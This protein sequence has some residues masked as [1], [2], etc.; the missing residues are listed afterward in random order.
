MLATP[1]VGHLPLQR[2]S[3]TMRGVTRQRLAPQSGPG[4]V[5]RRIWR[6]ASSIVRRHIAYL[7]GNRLESIHSGRPSRLIAPD[8]RDANTPK[9]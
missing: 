7:T 2:E 3:T 6:A 1:E 9:K 8:G 5:L 4:P